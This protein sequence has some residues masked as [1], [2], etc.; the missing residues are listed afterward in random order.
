M[1]VKPCAQ[2]C[3]LDVM[4]DTTYLPAVVTHRPTPKRVGK[5]GIDLCAQVVNHIGLD[6]DL[7]TGSPGMIGRALSVEAQNLRAF[8][9]HRCGMG[10]VADNAAQ[11]ILVEG[12]GQFEP[13]HKLRHH[14]L[15]YLCSVA[16][17][18]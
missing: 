7:C 9:Q 12:A 17:D 18:A 11:N 2:G 10:N 14:I 4:L 8:T 6:E 3:H 5:S 13:G 16:P 1:L 15:L